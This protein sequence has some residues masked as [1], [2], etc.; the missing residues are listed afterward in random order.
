M[1]VSPDVSYDAESGLYVRGGGPFTGTREER[2]ASGRLSSRME[3]VDGI[4]H[5][6]STSW[7]PDGKVATHAEF[8]GGIRHGVTRCWYGSG[9]PRSEQLFEYGS[10]RAERTWSETGALVTDRVSDAFGPRFR[11]MKHKYPGAPAVPARFTDTAA[12]A[13]QRL[14]TLR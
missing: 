9:R 3:F 5:G 1:T 14:S 6:V 12:A 7:F 8:V 10:L 11:T 4:H 2:D 13:F